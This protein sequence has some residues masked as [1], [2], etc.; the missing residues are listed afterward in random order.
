MARRKKKRKLTRVQ[1]RLITILAGLM[2]VIFVLVVILIVSDPKKTEE[3]KPQNIISELLEPSKEETIKRGHVTN[4]EIS[5]AGGVEIVH[6]YIPWGSPRR[7]GE[8]REIRYITIHETDN[9][10]SGADA[11]AHA[12][13]LSTNVSDITSWHYTVDDSSIYHHVPD[14]EIAWNAGDNRTKNGGNING[15]G[16]EMCVNLA[17]DYER[18]LRNTAEL[19]A[20]LMIAYDLDMECIRFHEDFMNKE[21]PHRLISEGR[22][23]EFLEMIRSAYVARLKDA[24]SAKGGESEV[25]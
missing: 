15:I 18:T 9:R 7:P 21:C 8:I 6:Q 19:A 22:T 16:I 17:N 14:N 24:Q 13:L 5:S 12:T 1:R 2:A 10:R 23:E 20:E 4:T 11:N 25:E 3:D